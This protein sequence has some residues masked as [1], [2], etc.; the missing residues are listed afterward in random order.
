MPDGAGWIS[1]FMLGAFRMSYVFWDYAIRQG[2]RQLISSLAYF[3]PLLATL[4]LIAGG[5]GATS[6]VIAL[7]AFLIVAGCLVTNNRQIRDVL[8]RK[9]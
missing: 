5:F 6:S 8:S 1:I 2:N 3:V 9:R 7:A 4:L